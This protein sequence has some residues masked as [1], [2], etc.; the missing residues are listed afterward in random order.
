MKLFLFCE[1]YL[2][3]FVP[4]I[5]LKQI[6]MK[7]I[8]TIFTIAAL[9]TAVA[10]G[11]AEKKE[12]KTEQEAE[13]MMDEMDDAMEEAGDDM[14]DAAEEVGEETEEAAEEVEEEMN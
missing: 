9:F 3:T 1:L 8:L 2:S 4:I 11:E 13:E 7:K 6:M 14:E 12:T 10:C 5:E